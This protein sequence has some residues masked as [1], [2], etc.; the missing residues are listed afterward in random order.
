MLKVNSV[1]L[2]VMLMLISCL[3]EKRI[4]I[5]LLFS[6]LAAVVVLFSVGLIAVNFAYETH[7]NLWDIIYATL[8]G[9]QNYWLG[10]LVAF[11]AIVA[12]PLIMESAQR[13][14]RFFLETANYFGASF[15]VPVLHADFSAISPDQESNTYTIYFSYFKDYGW[16]GMII[17]MMSLG[18][19]TTW[20]YKA[21]RSGSPVVVGIYSMLAT[22]LLLSIHA[23]HFVLGLN[24]YLKALIFFVLI[25]HVLARMNLK[26]SRWLSQIR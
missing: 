20:V 2:I 9:I 14:N 10:S 21:T 22:G 24:G 7:N 11:D 6:C 26:S 19:L 17:G 23:E 15:Y 3:R 13:L 18:G 4:R 16:F 25:Y 8:L 5:K 12:D 1:R